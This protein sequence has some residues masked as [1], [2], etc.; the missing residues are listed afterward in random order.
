[1]YTIYFFMLVAVSFLIGSVPTGYLI[2]KLLKGK[3]IRNEG[4]RNIGAT[5]VLRA[6]GK[7]PAVIVLALDTLKGY[8]AVKLASLLP[9]M[10][11][12][13]F[14]LASAL[15]VIA[16]HCWTIFLGFKGGKGVATGLGAFLAIA[17]M[18]T[19]A[20]AVVFFIVIIL[21]RY[22]SLASMLASAALPVI[23]YFTGKS[24]AFSA[25]A[26][27]IALLIIYRH[28]E[29]ILRI[30]QGNENKIGIKTR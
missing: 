3:D 28:R 16:G 6:T 24:A 15:F 1:M 9:Y 30:I 11:W 26:S 18:Q 10:Q 7:L 5:N 8:L 29:N 21:S 25:A 22:V 19:A 2:V 12:E 4:S 23:C 17:P 27:L 13:L 14:T 20:S